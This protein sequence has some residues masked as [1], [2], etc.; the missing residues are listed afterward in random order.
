MNKT[1]YW[2]CPECGGLTGGGR[3]KDHVLCV[4]KLKAKHQPKR[5][6]QNKFKYGKN[7]AFMAKQGETK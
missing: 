4:K 5:P 7:I 2:I 1:P 6:A 3:T